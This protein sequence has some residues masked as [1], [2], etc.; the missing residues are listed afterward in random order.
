[1]GETA[2]EARRLDR[3]VAGVVDRAVERAQMRRQVVD[4]LGGDPVLAHRLVLGADVL[5]LLLVRGEPQAAVTRQRV[6][7]ERLHAVERALRPLPQ[8]ARAFNA[9]RLTSDLIT[10]R[11]AAQREAAVAPA[12]AL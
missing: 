1:G 7:G 11:T 9:V 6:A 4:P 5:A 2:D 10:R 3:A 12:R 8:A